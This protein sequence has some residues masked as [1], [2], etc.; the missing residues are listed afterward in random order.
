MTDARLMHAVVF[1][2]KAEAPDDTAAEIAKFYKEEISQVNGVEHVFVGRPAG[3]DR[4]VVDGSYQ[5][6]SALVF[7]NEGVATAW[8]S[9]PVHDTFRDR[10]GPHFERVTIYDTRE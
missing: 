9:D 8:Q 1:W 4:D 2:L 7:A 5:V 6:M 3:T 10:F